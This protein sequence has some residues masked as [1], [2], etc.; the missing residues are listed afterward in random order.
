[1]LLF[2]GVITIGSAGATSAGATITGTATDVQSGQ[3]ITGI[4]VDAWGTGG[5]AGS[6]QTDLNGNY[7]LSVP[8]GSYLIVF[9]SRSPSHTQR[10]CRRS[11]TPAEN[12]VSKSNAGQKSVSDPRR[13]PTRRSVYGT[14]WTTAVVSALAAP[15]W[16]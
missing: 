5:E 4:C 9:S 7:V 11:P 15:S 3:R 8:A 2:G 1:M 13:C 14:L 16:L 12:A 6:A 10:P